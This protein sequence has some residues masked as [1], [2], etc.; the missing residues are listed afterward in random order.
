MNTSETLKIALNGIEQQVCD[1]VIY[2]Y[3]K[4]VHTQ[5]KLLRKKLGTVPNHA[6]AKWHSG[7]LLVAATSILS[8]LSLLRLYPSSLPRYPPPPLY[9][10]LPRRNTLLAAFPIISTLFVFCTC[11]IYGYPNPLE[12]PFV[13]ASENSPHERHKHRTK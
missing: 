5:E 6:F 2:I 9:Y 13:Q 3:S 1:Y 12:D 10:C 7:K 11:G 8:L 4:A